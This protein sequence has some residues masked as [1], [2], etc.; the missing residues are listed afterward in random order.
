MHTYWYFARSKSTFSWNIHHTVYVPVFFPPICLILRHILPLRLFKFSCCL[1]L[2]CI[3]LLSILFL[4]W[5]L[6]FTTT[7]SS[8]GSTSGRGGVTGSSRI[9]SFF[10]FLIF[11]RLKKLQQNT[12]RLQR[13]IPSCLNVSPF[14][15][16]DG[17]EMSSLDVSPSLIRDWSILPAV[18]AKQE[19]RVAM[20]DED[21]GL[22]GADLIRSRSHSNRRFLSSQT[23]YSPY[24]IQGQS[25][26]AHRVQY[27][28][29]RDFTRVQARLQA[30]LPV[31]GV[32]SCKPTG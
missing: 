19:R 3:A 7:R 8:G 24:S 11:L 20:A 4:R 12:L 21:G 16:E 10:V 9:T 26:R 30:L 31:K 27:D 25:S 18:V 22:G 15:P 23:A 6:A 29:T 14:T 17:P 32:V 13:K 1:S 2:V 28:K 5:W